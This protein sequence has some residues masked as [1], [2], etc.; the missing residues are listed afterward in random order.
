MARLHLLQRRCNMPNSSVTKNALGAGLKKVMKT[1]PFSKVV[2]DDIAEACNVSRGTFYYHF[3]DKYD[4]LNWVFST[5]VTPILSK[6][7]KPSNWIDGYVELCKFML[8]SKQ[9][10]LRVFEFVG[11]NSPHQF[12]LDFYTELFASDDFVNDSQCTYKSATTKEMRS[13]VARLESFAYVGIITEWVN[14]GMDTDYMANIEELKAL[15]KTWG[16]VIAS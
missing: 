11:Q 8:K 9:F 7:N 4:L 2:V 16:T 10:Y 12:L 14:S 13:I 1:K 5:E 6:Y 3:T 15:Q